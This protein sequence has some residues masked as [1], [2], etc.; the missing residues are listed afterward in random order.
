MSSACGHCAVLPLGFSRPWRCLCLCL[1]LRA[2][3]APLLS[4]PLLVRGHALGC[5]TCCSTDLRP[6]SKGVAKR[7]QLPLPT[8]IETLR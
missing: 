6:L 7:T 4:L 5:P 2:A 1:Y 8:R 3:M